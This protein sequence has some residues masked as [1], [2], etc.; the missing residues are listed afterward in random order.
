MSGRTYSASEGHTHP[1]RGAVLTMIGPRGPHRGV[2][3][4]CVS[5]GA[6]RDVQSCIRALEV[7]CVRGMKIRWK[8][9]VGCA[10][11]K[12]LPAP[13][14]NNVHRADTEGLCTPSP[15]MQCCDPIP[16]HQGRLRERNKRASLCGKPCTKRTTLNMLGEGG[17]LVYPRHQSTCARYFRSGRTPKPWW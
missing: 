11:E 16:W 13:S 9:C 10:S 1:V 4:V 12:S 14:E 17:T 6:R 7:V 3:C 15:T 5:G 2:R 8:P